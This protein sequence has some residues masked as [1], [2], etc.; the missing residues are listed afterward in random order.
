MASPKQ[1]LEQAAEELVE[2]KLRLKAAQE[3]FDVLYRQAVSGSKAK[4][5]SPGTI[6]E[7]VRTTQIINAVNEISAT[8][9]IENV[10][11]SDG[12][13][14][15]NYQE[16]EKI[17]PDIPKSSIRALLYKL[18]NNGKALKVGR[19]LWK[20]TQPALVKTVNSK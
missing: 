18:K 6:Q 10:L 20:S 9:R 5:S 12:N 13:K 2:A 15:W 16:I 17:L 3:K 7:T 4:R 8:S 19:G 1:K 11:D 14:S